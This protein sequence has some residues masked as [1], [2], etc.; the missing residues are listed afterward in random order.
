MTLIN[1][2]ASRSKKSKVI[3]K[4]TLYPNSL[5][6]QMNLGEKFWRLPDST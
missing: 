1:L 3:Y 5:K 6:F 4:Y 2:L